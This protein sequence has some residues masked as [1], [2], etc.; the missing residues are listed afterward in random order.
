MSISDR[1]RKNRIALP[2]VIVYCIST[3]FIVAGKK[4]LLQW[5][6]DP[7]VV[8]I[9]NLLLFIVSITSLFLYQRAMAHPTTMGFLRN[10][11]SGLFFKLLVCIFAVMIYVL[12]ARKQINKP[13]LFACIFLYFLYALLEMRSLM[14]WN[15]ARR[16]A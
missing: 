2:L 11:Y 13:A 5:G 4:W 10:T 1:F 6:V 15:K 3:A 9:G 16:N 12:V 7:G 8:I 14:Q